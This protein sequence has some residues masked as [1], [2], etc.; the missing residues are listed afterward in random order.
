MIPEPGDPPSSQCPP[1][2][3]WAVTHRGLQL[4]KP[5]PQLLGPR[6]RHAPLHTPVWTLWETGPQIWAD[7]N[8]VSPRWPGEARR[9]NLGE[10]R[11]RAALCQPGSWCW[12]GGR[13]ACPS[14]ARRVPRTFRF[15]LPQSTHTAAPLTGS[16]HSP[17][18]H[19]LHHAP[20]SRAPP[21]SLWPRRHVPGWPRCGPAGCRAAWPAAPG[22]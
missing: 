22:T 6:A 1:Q 21:G 7:G 10:G 8:A 4:Y 18:A 3:A 13:Q 20:A 16:P 2:Q 12:L 19:S 5:G 17:A 11:G 15:L 9:S 14:H